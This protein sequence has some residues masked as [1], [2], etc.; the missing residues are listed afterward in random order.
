MIANERRKCIIEML[1]QRRAT[2]TDVL[3]DIFQVSHRTSR[4]VCQA[5]SV[6]SLLVSGKPRHIDA[7]RQNSTRSTK[8]NENRTSKEGWFS[9][10]FFYELSP[11]ACIKTSTRRTTTHSTKYMFA[12]IFLYTLRQAKQ[13][14][15]M[16]PIGKTE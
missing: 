12:S 1:C 8:L 16:V 13:A 5:Q 11:D 6:S 7:L 15:A 4:F 9:F 14:H 10:C 2:T 3:A